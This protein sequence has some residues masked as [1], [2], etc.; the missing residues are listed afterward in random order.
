MSTHKTRGIVEQGK[1]NHAHV[2]TVRILAN[3]E[4]M[5]E[6]KP[7]RGHTAKTVDL[8][9]SAGATRAHA[10][11]GEN[12]DARDAILRA[13]A[14]WAS[15]RGSKVVWDVDVACAV[16]YEPTPEG[17]AAFRKELGLETPSTPWPTKPEQ[18]PV[19]GPVVD[20]E[21]HPV[22]GSKTAA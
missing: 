15:N 5:S 17:A 20:R 6:L 13:A 3:G 8:K 7:V 18:N 4:E 14:Q 9:L 21:G 22:K 16:G 11:V 10:L 2:S 12:A 19:E 1:G